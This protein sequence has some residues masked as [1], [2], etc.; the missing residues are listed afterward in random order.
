MV[1][2][3]VRIITSIITNKGASAGADRQYLMCI[4]P[5]LVE[6]NSRV[7]GFQNRN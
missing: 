6:L 2:T 1:L 7:T 5:K 3:C 4:R